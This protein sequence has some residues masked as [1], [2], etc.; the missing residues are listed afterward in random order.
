MDIYIIFDDDYY[1]SRLLMNYLRDSVQSP[2][3]PGGPW[4]GS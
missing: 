4:G 3:P 1:L 2:G